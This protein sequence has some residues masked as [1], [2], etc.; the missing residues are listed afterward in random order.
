MHA[1]LAFR[2]AIIH[3]TNELGNNTTGHAQFSARLSR[4][5]SA[6]G[7]KASELLPLVPSGWDCGTEG[8]DYLQVDL[9]AVN[10]E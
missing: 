9:H 7:P 1:W 6:P 5:S 3:F 10:G 8:W 2:T 4:S